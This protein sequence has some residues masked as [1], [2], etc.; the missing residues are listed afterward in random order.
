M[1]AAL[2]LDPEEIL[3]AL[4]KVPI[5]IAQ[6]IAYPLTLNSYSSLI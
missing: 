4:V 1:K 5:A 3:S 2:D 6:I